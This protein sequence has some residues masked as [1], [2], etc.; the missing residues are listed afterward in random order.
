[1]GRGSSLKRGPFTA[2]DVKSALKADGWIRSTKGGGHQTM[3]THPEKPGKFP[4]SEAW[5]NLDISDPILRGMVRTCGID[6]K[7]LLQLLNGIKNA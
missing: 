4:V 1:V 7:R 5:K 2:R 3:W 6:K